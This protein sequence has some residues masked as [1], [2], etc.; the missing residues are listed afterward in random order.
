VSSLYELSERYIEL[1]MILVENVSAED[2]AAAFAELD[3]ELGDKLDSCAHVLA[4]LESDRYAVRTEI[5]RLEDR[6]RALDSG[7]DWL[8]TAMTSTL[9]AAGLT[10]H[11]S[12]LHTLWI[13]SSARAIVHDAS[14]LPAEYVR[15][16]PAVA[17][18]TEP[19]LDRIRKA[20]LASDETGETIPG[21]ELQVTWG[22]RRR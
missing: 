22:L 12:P 15:E 4:S 14:A 1:S 3:G 17:A 9:Q 8:R 11:K 13:Q 19:A 2:R 7:I 20:L 16:I 5:A 6:A 10:R 18:R 21:A